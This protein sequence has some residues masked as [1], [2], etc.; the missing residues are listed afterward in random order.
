MSKRPL[1][2]S[3]FFTSLV[4]LLTTTA[5]AAE[6]PKK[7]AETATPPGTDAVGEIPDP[8]ADVNDKPIPRALYEAYA[9]QRQRQMG[10]VNSPEARKTLTDEMVAQELLIQ[11]AEKSTLEDNPEV[12][13]QLEMARRNVLATAAVRDYLQANEP[14]QEE[15]DQEYKTIS[16]NM[17]GKEYKARHILVASEDEASALIEKLDDGANFSELATENSTDS[18]ASSGGDLGWFTL[19]V[20]VK[21]FGDAAAK[22]ETGKY[23]GTPVQTQFGWHIIMLDDVRDATPPSLEEL[24]PRI[25][26]MIQSRI[27]ND[28]LQSLRE[29]A[30]IEIM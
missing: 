30:K 5:G 23:T 8:V 20:M 26:Q 25:M 12:A 17:A 21:P 22:L 19:D 3:V 24:R 15:I 28:Y 14:S 18:S 9:E 6:D 4:F 29:K 2:L 7:I 13:V 10:D 1:L 16:A 27:I 11:D